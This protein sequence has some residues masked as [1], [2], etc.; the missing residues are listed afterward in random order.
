MFKDETAAE[1]DQLKAEN[2]RLKEEFKVLLDAM[3]YEWK[4]GDG[5]FRTTKAAME[6]AQKALGTWKPCP[7]TYTHSTHGKLACE[8]DEGHLNRRYDV[9]HTNGDQKWMSV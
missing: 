6:R 3:E 2:Q 4:H 7:S 5:I 9:E 1:L 8:K